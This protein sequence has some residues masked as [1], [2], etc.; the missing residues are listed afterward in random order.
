[1]NHK[2]TKSRNNVGITMRFRN[3]S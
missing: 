3:C 2:N 1:M